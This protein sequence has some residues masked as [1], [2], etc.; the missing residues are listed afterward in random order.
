MAH[1]FA[2]NAGKFNAKAQRG[3]GA[4]KIPQGIKDADF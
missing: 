3:K 1:S 4:I 2:A